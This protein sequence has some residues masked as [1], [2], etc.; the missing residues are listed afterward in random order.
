M[1]LKM[2]FVLD[3]GPARIEAIWKS[4]RSREL[5][6]ATTIVDN[7][8]DAIFWLSRNLHNCGVISLTHDLGG[9][10]IR[11]GFLWDPGTGRD[12][13]NYLAERSPVCP[14]ILHTDNFFV[15]P[16]M[17]CILDRG[18]WSHSFVAPG[19][20]MDWVEKEWLPKVLAG[21]AADCR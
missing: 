11:D 9:E 17:Q 16:Q 12:I 4:L 8:P 10:Q 6:K 18:E 21:L 7:V 5:D 20:R 15:R 2:I 19:N 13:A 3:N 1:A 14:V